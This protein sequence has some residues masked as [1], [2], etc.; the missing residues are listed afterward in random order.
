MT[1][2]PRV[3]TTRILSDAETL[4]HFTL[5]WPTGGITSIKLSTTASTL[6]SSFLKLI[7]SENVNLKKDAANLL[8]WWAI[9]NL[10]ANTNYPCYSL[11]N[12]LACLMPWFCILQDCLVCLMIQW[13]TFLCILKWFHSLHMSR[14][15]VKW[16]VA[17][18]LLTWL[19][20]LKWIIIMSAMIPFLKIQSRQLVLPYFLS[21]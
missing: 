6:C 15:P 19:T 2:W 8:W 18:Q 10:S 21:C 9:S 17:M 3:E 12:C 14:S 5:L 16:S 20:G 13:A 7:L 11:D 1:N 4:S